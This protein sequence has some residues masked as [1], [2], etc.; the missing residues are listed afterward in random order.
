MSLV[1]N[2]VEIVYA[3]EEKIGTPDLFVGRELEFKKFHQWINKIPKK[4][5]KSRALLGRRKSGKTA[6]VQRLFNQVWSTNGQVIPFFFSIPEVPIWYPDFAMRYY[7]AFASQYI[8]FLERDPKLV[9]TPWTMPEILTYV[10][11]NN[12]DVLARDVTSMLDDMERGHYG[13]VWDTAYRAPH[14]LAAFYEQFILVMIDEFQYLSGNIYARQDLSG[15]PLSGMPGSYHEVSESKVAPM[16]ATGSYV[17]WMLDIMHKHLKAGRLSR[18]SFSPYLTESEGL[19]AVYTYAEANEEPIS[20]V[21]AIQ[22][23]KLCNS[24]PF[25]ISC[26]IQSDYPERNLTDPDHVIDT[27]NYEASDRESELAETWQEYIDLVV[28]RINDTYGKQLLLH[29]SK[30]NDRHWTPKQLKQTLKLEETEQS[31]KRKLHALVKAD[32]IEWGKSD[33]RFQG[34]RDGTLNLILQ[35]RFAEEIEEYEPDLR[36][37]LRDQTAKLQREIKRLKG[38]LCDLKG[39]S[40]EFIVVN[41]L[42]TKKRF[43]LSTYFDG[44]TDDVRLN[45]TNVRMRITIH[46]DDDK[47]MELDVVATDSNHYVLVVEVRNRDDKAMPDDI[48]DFYE[49]VEVYRSQNPDVTVLAAFVSLAGFTKNAQTMCKKYG[50]VSATDLDKF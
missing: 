26:V 20:N 3:L 31:I 22:I 50:I 18:T 48:E 4:L 29:L 46:R 16:L 13:L 27:V 36:P 15:E 1:T 35:S 45:I 40:A 24:D 11:R 9:Q 43:S 17:G 19:K 32:L 47:E 41:G 28:D 23:N 38:Q 10:E 25:F 30:Y 33:I 14:Q 49:K 21:T 2:D 44:V 8:S 34:L 39:K 5:S 42:R 6:F 37:M 7:R 12:L